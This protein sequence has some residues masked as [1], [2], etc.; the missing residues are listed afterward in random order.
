MIG[1]DKKKRQQQKKGLNQPASAF[2]QV[3][4]SGTPAITASS[5]P[6][7]AAESASPHMPTSSGAIW[8][9]NAPT[10]T[11]ADALMMPTV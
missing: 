4:Q 8:L 9:Q 1:N 7:A 6:P 10:R 2:R 11:A 5:S 3:S